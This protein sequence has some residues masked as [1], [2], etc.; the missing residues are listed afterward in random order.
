VA[1]IWSA[2][3]HAAVPGGIELIRLPDDTTGASY[4]GHPVLIVNRPGPVAVVGISLDAPLGRSFLDVDAQGQG[5][6][7]IAFNVVPKSYP[8]QRLT[9][10]DD[11]MVNPPPADLVRIDRE[12][13]LMKAQYDVFSPLEASPFPLVL[14][15][16]GR[17][18]SNFGLRRIL[19]GESRNP[20]AGIDIA[21]KVGDPVTAPA[22]GRIS[23]TGAFYFNGNTIFVDH[24]GG[25]IS[26]VCHLSA[27]EVHDGDVV[28]R[29]ERIGRVGATGRATG[30]HLHWSVSMNGQRVD[31]KAALA[32]FH[33]A[34]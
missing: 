14:P 11:K 23:L 12:T 10:A 24:G 15:A 2:G 13:A 7:Q 17:V 25:M 6:H 16:A 4:G 1:I 5:K 30:P 20:H 34:P 32:L 3:V 18:S 21:A 29:G 26:M 27:I 33:K 8:V 19:N 28:K 31:P 9:L 22:P